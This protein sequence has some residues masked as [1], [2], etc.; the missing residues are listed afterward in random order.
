ML[1]DLKPGVVYG[2]DNSVVLAGNPAPVYKVFKLNKK[3]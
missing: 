2:I 1:N 3:T